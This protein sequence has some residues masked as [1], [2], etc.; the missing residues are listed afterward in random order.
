[1]YVF[2]QTG[3]KRQKKITSLGKNAESLGDLFFLCSV[4]IVFTIIF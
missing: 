4:C 2:G 3:K 1:M